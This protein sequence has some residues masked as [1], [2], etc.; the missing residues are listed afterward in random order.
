MGR[1]SRNGRRA[2]LKFSVANRL[3]S[4][5]DRREGGK[6]LGLRRYALVESPVRRKQVSRDRSRLDGEGRRARERAAGDGVVDVNRRET[7]AV[8]LLEVIREG[9]TDL[10]L[11]IL[12]PFPLLLGAL[13]EKDR[14]AVARDDEDER[15]RRAVDE[16]VVAAGESSEYRREPRE[17]GEARR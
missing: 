1:K 4:S 17:Q 13:P 10:L 15:S 12:V 14:A 11:L 8:E 5:V 9:E 6:E 2:K 7:A 16:S 3:A